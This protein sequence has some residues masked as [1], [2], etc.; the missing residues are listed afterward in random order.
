M[1]DQTIRKFFYLSPDPAPLKG[2][3][4]QPIALLV[5]EVEHISYYGLSSG[6]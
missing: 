5:S 2:Y 3:G 4:M 6:K 1:D